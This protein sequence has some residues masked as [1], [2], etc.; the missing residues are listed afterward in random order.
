ML[1]ELNLTN[2]KTSDGTIIS[3]ILQSICDPLIENLHSSHNFQIFLI[4]QHYLQCL[5][6]TYSKFQLN[7]ASSFEV[8]A[9]E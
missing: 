6:S 2:V 9:L 1:N 5:R 8:I 4:S 7:Q 3:D